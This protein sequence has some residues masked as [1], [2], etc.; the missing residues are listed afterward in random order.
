MHNEKFI[1]SYIDLINNNFISDEH[2]FIVLG[3]NDLENIPLPKYNNIHILDNSLANLSSLF[4]LN[5]ILKPYF[6]SASKII[7]HSLFQQYYLNILLLNQKILS[8]CYAI[9]WGGDLYD[10][11]KRYWLSRSFISILK[12]KILIPKIAY[13]LMYVKGDFELAKKWYGAKGQYIENFKYPSNLYK[14]LEIKE[15]QEETIYIQVGNSAD[16]TNQ[17]IKIFNM[18]KIYKDE[19]IKIIV[20]LSYGN[21]SNAQLIMKSGYEIFGDKFQ[22]L[23]EVLPLN[24]YLEILGKID[25]AIFNHNRQ[26]AMGNIITLLGLGKKVF[27]RD[28]I[29]PWKMFQDKNIKIFNIKELNLEILDE[30]DK[31]KNIDIVKNYFSQETYLKQLQMIFDDGDTNDTL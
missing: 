7:V 25:I 5:N 14:P 21:K 13:F 23:N 11:K 22:P 10:Y 9:M 16:V 29:T 24:K 2:V 4:K 28:T 1:A 3:G 8:K 15:S 31:N 30:E 12:K 17:H 6:N 20:P 26:Q 18:L 19:N 27:I